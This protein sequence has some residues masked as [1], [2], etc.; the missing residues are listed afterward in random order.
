[1][2]EKKQIAT[3]PAGPR[4]DK[5][6]P[7][8]GDG[9]AFA[10][11]APKLTERELEAINGLF[12]AFIFR[13][14]KTGEY[15]TTCCR[16]H[17]VLDE[18]RTVT[19]AMR[20]LMETEH[21]PEP[22]CSWGLSDQN[23]RSRTRVKCPHCGAEATLKELGQTGLRQNLWSWRRAAVLRWH[24]GA[25]WAVCWNAKKDYSANAP[26]EGQ[27]RLTAMPTGWMTAALRFRPGMAEATQLLYEYR[28]EDWGK[29][30]CRPVVQTEPR[31]KGIPFTAG[32]VFSHCSEYGTGYDVIGW[33]ELD[34]SPFRYI[35]LQEVKKK[36]GVNL[37]RLLTMACVYPV[38]MEMLHKFGFDSIIRNYADR[39]VKT[40]WL[41]DWAATDRKKFLKLP[42]K[43][44][45]ANAGTE[46]KLEALRIWKQRKGKDSLE[47]CLWEVGEL[48][49]RYQR[50]RVRKR[51]EALGLSL[52]RMRNYLQGQQGPRQTV[53]YVEQLWTDY[54]DAAEGLGLDLANEVIHFPKDL[55]AAHDKRCGEMQ[56]LRALR[57][58]RERE[59]REKKEKRERLR[60]LNTRKQR[61]EFAFGGL[62]VIL[63]EDPDEIIQEGKALHHCVGGYAARHE[64]GKTT[65]LF[66]RREDAPE[67]SLVTIEIYGQQ[68]RQAHG[69]RNEAEPCADNPEQ[70]KPEYLYKEFFDA[71]KA[72]MKRGSPR[73][74]D[75]NPKI[76][77]RKAAGKAGQNE[78]KAG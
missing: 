60:E 18:E 46:E 16:R 49:N 14:S 73:D 71:W 2:D 11:L 45:Q 48:A 67:K 22:K 5:P 29:A 33:E 51:M 8:A 21:A 3:G 31:K 30:W 26:L 61:Y 41:I 36:T 56:K 37:L 78:R 53:A 13:R 6:K 58:K 70:L 35:K 10:A 4:N 23:E 38:Q 55:K 32:D 76:G 42:L 7:F 28:Q 34:K 54:M 27:N 9:E 19:P 66:L 72:W 59:A 24:R 69:W 65:I 57:A 15:W 39:G 44:V 52:K 68:I 25:L 75:G 17:V 77:K 62:R 12:R 40:A 64:E 47:D 43:T 1:M 50:D 74:K 63:P 20:G